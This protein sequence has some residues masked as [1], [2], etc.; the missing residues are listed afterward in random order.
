MH[1]SSLFIL[2]TTL[3]HSLACSGRLKGVSDDTLPDN[4]SA[5]S[6]SDAGGVAGSAQ[7]GSA[8]GGETNSGDA[9]IEPAAGAGGTSSLQGKTGAE[10]YQALCAPC[11]G[12]TG[13]GSALAPELQHPVADF[14]TWVVR[15]GRDSDSYAGPMIAYPETIVSDQQLE[16][17]WTWLG[18]LPQPTTGEALYVDYCANCHGADARGGRVG[19]NIQE[20]GNE[21]ADLTEKVREGEGGTNYGAAAMYMPH[22]TTTQISNEELT[23]IAEHLTTL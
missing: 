22:W 8:Q 17:I 21:L 7:G 5:G 19:Q 16:E 18:S 4:G 2:V 12:P 3:I 15:S 1:R 9:G 20:K 23:L 6:T 13:E 14:S 11:H 10:V